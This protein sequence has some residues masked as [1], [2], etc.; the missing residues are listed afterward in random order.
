M[1]D[2]SPA[3]PSG[4]RSAKDW[5]IF[6]LGALVVFL[7]AVVVKDRAAAGGW[8][9]GLGG[10]ERVGVFDVLLD[11][12]N[13]SYIDI[14]FDRPLGEGKEG[15][16]LAEPPA[17]LSPVVGGVWRWRDAAA[18]RFE[19]TDRLEMA[20]EYTLA[21]LPDRLLKAGQRLQ[22]DSHLKVRT[23][24]FLVEA[25]EV[26]EEPAPEAGKGAVVLRGQLRFNYAVDPDE[27]APRLRLNDPQGGEVRVLLTSTYSSTGLGFRTVPVSKLPAA[28]TL[29]LTVAADLTPAEGNVPLPE[30]YRS[31]IPLGSSET[32]SVR[33]FAAVPGE[34]ESA[35]RI[36][37]SS[38][39]SAE[40]AARFVKVTPA[41]TFRAAAEGN[42]L[43][44]TGGFRPGE[45]YKVEVAQGL[46]ASDGAVLAAA[47]SADLRL[48]DLAPEVRFQSDGYFLSKSGA[49]A[50]AV[51]SINV[52]AADLT[53]DRVFR[54]NLFNLLQYQR[55]QLFG[56]SYRGSSVSHALGGRLAEEKLRF[57]PERNR[58]TVTPV[59]LDR[60]LR[61]DE[62]GFYRVAISREGSYDAEQ[63]WVLITDIGL[64][65]KR[66]EGE[67]LVWAS[68]FANLDPIAGARV[69]LVSDQNQVVA[70]GTTGADGLVRLDFSGLGDA[71]P[72][73]VTAERG[74]DW[75]FLALDQSQVDMTGLDVGGATAERSGY[76][77]FLYGE[78]DLYRPGEV[79]EGLAVVRDRRL[80][81]P[82]A[83][84]VLL[85]HRDAQGQ[86]RESQRLTSDAKGLVPF[87]LELAAYEQTGHHTLELKAGER[88]I[89]QYR[90]QV[91]EFIPDRIKVAIEP[92]KPA[93]LAG[94]PLGFD[95][96][97]AYL[98]GPPAA[99]LETKSRIRL[100]AATF[101][102]KGLE[103]FAFSNA[104][105][106]LQETDLLTETATLDDSGRAHFETRVPT[107]LAPPSMLEAVLTARAEEKGGR[108]VT[109]MARLPVHAYARYVG[110]R[111]LGEGYVEAGEELPLEWVAVAPDGKP[112]ASGSLR[113]D[114][115]HDRWNTVL[116]RSDDGSTFR[117]ESVRDPQLVES[118][119]LEG[120]AER[121]SFKLRPRNYG[122]HR[123]VI[124]DLG[125]GASAQI[126]FY[127]G[128]WGYS[129]WAVQNPGRL[130]LALDR[131]SYPA[132]STAT[133]Q[134]RSPFPGKLLLSVE[135]DGVLATSVH[136][137]SGNTATIPLTVEGGWRP[138]VY[139]TATL[140]R[141][142]KDLEPGSPGRAFGAVPLHVDRAD[143][144]LQLALSAPA[145]MRPRAPLAVE[146][147]GEPG[148]VVTVAAVDE[149]ILRL[150]GQE[151]PDPFSYFYRKLALG[152]TS[153]DTFALLMPEP[154]GQ[155]AGGG[156]GL[157]QLGQFVSTAAMLRLEPAA[158]WSGPLTLGS[159]GKALAKFEVGDLQGALR[160]MVVGFDADRFGSE[161]GSVVVRD[162]VVVLPT[163]PRFLQLG[164]RAQ[165]PLTV[166][167]DTGKDGELE[168][169]LRWSL[170]GEAEQN[171]STRVNVANGR[172]QTVYLDL[173]VGQQA[174]VMAVTATVSG[175][176]ENS[177]TSL[178][179]PV[180]PALPAQS[181]FASGALDAAKATLPAVPEGLRPETVTRRLTLSPYPLVR[182]GGRL[183]D[184]LAYPYGCIEQTVSRTF[185]L[186]Y[187]GDLAKELEPSLF[188]QAEPDVWV[189]EGLR[190]LGAMQL[191]NGG[192]AMWPGETLTEAWPSIY[193]THLL[194]EADKAGHAVDGWML[195]QALGYLE[196][197][198]RAK[199][200]YSRGE[201]QRMT[202]SL[203]VLAR[204]GR[205]DL[206]SM[207]FLREKHDKDLT[208]ESRGLLAAAY[209][210]LGNPQAAEQLA[211]SLTD[212]ETVERGRSE[213]FASTVR[214]R[215]LLL[216]ALLDVAPGDARVPALA[217]RL[218]RD[219]MA[220]D[221]WNTQDE[222]FALLAVGKL[223]SDQQQQGAASGIITLGGQ[224]AGS[225]EGETRTWADL[226]GSAPLGVELTTGFRPGA[227]Y[228]SQVVRGVLR[229]DAFR[230]F[231]D[232]LE[233]EREVLR[234]DGS[235]ASLDALAQGELLVLRTRVRSTSGPLDNVVI[236]NLLPSGL[237][238]EN[239]RLRTTEQVPWTQRPGAVPAEQLLDASAVDLR[240]D[241][242]LAFVGLPD[243][244]W[245]VL[246]SVVRAV[247]PGTYRLPPAQVEAMYQPALK[248]SSGAGEIRV[249]VHQ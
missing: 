97:A 213:N 15:Q 96:A 175:N 158:Y 38:A 113:V 123:V 110:L 174:G 71:N 32:L 115:Y 191:Q 108:G 136:R 210:T 172:E 63:R 224:R 36:A 81:A 46:A 11:H 94:E 201:L 157:A 185:P 167:N 163:L 125:S 139:L 23:D 19:P 87:R 119:A 237:E 229:D 160:L 238:V 2:N 225:Y 31:E 131:E 193:A 146:V 249:V 169:G 176:G 86:E 4:R 29:T 73:L 51:E 144:Q 127:T 34:H 14:L 221:R 216:L 72:Y 92:A 22:G 159:D 95:V 98:F 180:R 190:R 147:R 116:R 118:R 178:R 16:V 141:P 246:Y 84:P 80:A 164:D 1:T 168:V 79:V 134:V 151:T 39:V 211:A 184:L 244:E 207:D 192:F 187:L 50:L 173:P 35:I 203:Y 222:A 162:R 12:E 130:E 5:T 52:S 135:R 56:G 214:N 156:E 205:A 109:A 49:R 18:L 202:Y 165:V 61:A 199:A 181:F 120:G 85:V 99:G 33:G 126:T 30:T 112:A 48:S 194:V 89:G 243:K 189:E 241:R 111:R 230:P 182:F 27:L 228:F 218:A 102:P 101:A 152:V 40:S 28:R 171:A 65:A 117:Y 69:Q 247:V 212:V 76:D 100:V 219:A 142:A 9:S 197:Q 43:V 62:P 245:R 122:A 186:L 242:I 21:L 25:V 198:V 7:G 42:D 106:Q 133:L 226:A 149:G 68:S 77:A 3:S 240:D 93:V 220:G 82:P 60:F 215:A 24:Q 138:N 121:G 143:K 41:V 239:P 196:S 104:E 236:S 57:K 6:L 114:L 231:A 128:G 183:R 137:L 13:L 54:N 66:T 20:T 227:V 37:L 161:T 235:K 145:E 105:R 53:V 200:L 59:R 75:S 140:I 208:A 153:Y 10:G 26:S 209:A 154:K 58:R 132:G 103:A 177:R 217:E 8:L 67:L 248:A 155:A 232:G 64:I 223:F 129:P 188:D 45:A 55:W 44:L 234:R 206:G 88:V 233:I 74:D 91:E 150:I 179:L 195:S 170:A 90:F 124:T 204:A 83:M 107:G 17:T 47:A 78:R 70:T 148:A 166:R